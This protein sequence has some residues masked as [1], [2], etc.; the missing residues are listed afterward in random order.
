M[1]VGSV[2]SGKTS[3]YIGLITKAADYGYKVIIVIAGIH[4]NLRKQTQERVNYGF[5]GYDR[6]STNLEGER[7]GVGKNLEKME[8]NLNLGIYFLGN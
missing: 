8:A 6:D 1:V 4:E 3:N 5:I 2:Q 7:I